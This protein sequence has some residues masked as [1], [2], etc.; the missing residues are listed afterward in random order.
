MNFKTRSGIL[1]EGPSQQELLTGQNLVTVK[2][3]GD[4]EGRNWE[5]WELVRV[6]SLLMQ[7]NKC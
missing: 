5:L 3:S 4:I 6:F 1:G 7:D 2:N